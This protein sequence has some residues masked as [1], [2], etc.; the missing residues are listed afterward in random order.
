MARML[1]YCTVTALAMVV[2]VSPVAS[3]IRWRW[4]NFGLV[5]AMC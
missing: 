5:V 3:E 1:G 2:K 4:K